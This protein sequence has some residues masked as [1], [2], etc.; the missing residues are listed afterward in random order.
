MT[1]LTDAAPPSSRSDHPH[2]RGH[3]VLAALRSP[4]L[5]DR[6]RQLTPL[7]IV[8]V[9]IWIAVARRS[10][11]VLPIPFLALY[12]AVILS[13]SAVGFRG[14]LIGGAVAGLFLTYATYAGF[15]PP[16]LD[17]GP[18]HVLFGPLLYLASGAFVGYRTGRRQRDLRILRRSAAVGLS[19]ALAEGYLLLDAEGA[20][21]DA[22]QPFASMIGVPLDRIIGRHVT[23]TDLGLTYLNPDGTPADVRTLPLALAIATGQTQYDQLIAVRRLDGNV[24]NVRLN[25]APEAG[26]DRPEYFVTTITDVTA[27]VADERELARLNSELAARSQER[28]ALVRQLLTAQEEERRTVAYDIHDGPAQQLTAAQMFLDAYEH[29]TN[30]AERSRYFSQA[31]NNLGDG[32]AETRRIM[33]GL[34]PALLD[35][36]GLADAVHTLVSEATRDTAVKVDFQASGLLERVPSEVEI[37]AYRVVQEAVSNALKHARTPLLCVRL[38]GRPDAVSVTIEDRGI[39]FAP[40]QVSAPVGGRHFGLVGMRERVDLLGGELSI[41]SA[42]G[43][44]TV[45]A[46]IIPL[47][48]TV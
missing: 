21:L 34:R 40:D 35:D 28:Q 14:G 10:D 26:A 27:R 38:H 5:L 20:V 39:G 13:A 18:R 19:D 2:L 4:L 47:A 32:L 31:R 30:P 41:D 9:I 44:G 6:L 33:S 48:M 1:H 22:N 11:D 8:L 29:E 3:T 25:I 46:A 37:T 23:N 24:I 43:R 45:V 7:A 36:V 15:G 12:A 16:G 42:L 17:S